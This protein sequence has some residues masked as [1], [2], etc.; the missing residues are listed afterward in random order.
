ML[1]STHTRRH[2]LTCTLGRMMQVAGCIHCWQDKSHKSLTVITAQ[3]RCYNLAVCFR[4]VHMP[5]ISLFSLSCLSRGKLVCFRSF[6]HI[7][8]NSFEYLGHSL[9]L[10]VCLFQ[11]VAVF[12]EVQRRRTDSPRENISNSSSSAAPSPEPVHYFPHLQYKERGEIEVNE[13][14]LKGSMSDLL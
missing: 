13:A 3:W 11:L 10:F 12:E 14:T 8:L 1:A 5:E 4:L 7:M 2:T 9:S 6:A